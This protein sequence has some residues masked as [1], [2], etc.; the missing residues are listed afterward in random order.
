MREL[1]RFSLTHINI[2]KLVNNLTFAFIKYSCLLGSLLLS[3]L[4]ALLLSLILRLQTYFCIILL[5]FVEQSAFWSTSRSSSSHSFTYIIFTCLIVQP[6]IFKS[7]N[8]ISFSVFFI[9][10]HLGY[11]STD[12]TVLN[13]LQCFISYSFQY[14][15]YLTCMCLWIGLSRL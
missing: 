3:P 8:P 2:S 5:L 9:R 6:L 11:L 14:L 10:I 12:I 13:T 1:C 4:V 15:F 7:S